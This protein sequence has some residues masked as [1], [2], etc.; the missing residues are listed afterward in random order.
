VPKTL[1]RNIWLTYKKALLPP[2]H[3]KLDLKQFVKAL[4]RDGNCFKYLCSKFPGLSDA[5]LKEGIFVGPDIRKLIS[6]EMFETTKSNA[7]R[8]AWIA[9]KD[10]IS[11]FFGKKKG[12]RITK[13]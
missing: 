12:T 4:Q 7:E 10:V 2:L 6:D 3:T 13:T 11:K 5:K 8:E 9:L 1:H